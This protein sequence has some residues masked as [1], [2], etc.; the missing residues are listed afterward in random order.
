MGVGCGLDTL[1]GRVDRQD[2]IDEGIERWTSTLD[3]YEVME[4]C[5]D[6]GVLAMPVQS[7]EDRVEN[8]PQLRARGSY[9]ELDHP[10]FGRREYQNTPFRLS[11]AEVEVRSSAPLIG[12]HTRRVAQTCWG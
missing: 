7:S 8:D 5:Q 9:K 1:E 4:R 6:A 12:Q 10:G 2:E 3:K 11:G